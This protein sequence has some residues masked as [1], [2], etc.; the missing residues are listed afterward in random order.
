MYNLFV[1]TLLLITIAPLFCGC[2]AI[3]YLSEPEDHK[4]MREKGYELCHLQ[5]CGP[6]AISD[7]Y[8]CFGKEKSAFDIGKE[9]QDR[10]K[11]DYRGILSA[12]HHDFTKITCPPELLSYLEYK[13]FKIKAVNKF[14]DLGPS[15]VAIVLLRGRN[16][17]KDWHYMTYPTHSKQEINNFFEDKTIIKKIYILK[18]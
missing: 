1:S 13:G 8:K 7:A 9:I 16:D 11:V 14:K 4:K 18:Q 6:E 17:L 2:G 12:A 15:D 3:Y 10:A 5:S